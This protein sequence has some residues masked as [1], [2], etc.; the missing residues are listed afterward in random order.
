MNNDENFFGN[1]QGDSICFEFEV[2]KNQE[3]KEDFDF[4]E[5]FQVRI[6]GPILHQESPEL[7]ELDLRPEIV[8]SIHHQTLVTKRLLPAIPNR[9]ERKETLYEPGLRQRLQQLLPNSKLI[10]SETMSLAELTILVDHIDLPQEVAQQFAPTFKDPRQ[11]MEQFKEQK[12]KI[13]QDTKQDIK[14]VS[15]WAIKH[16]LRFIQE[17]YP[18]MTKAAIESGEARLIGIAIILIIVPVLSIDI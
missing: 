17:L 2:Q 5:G 11:D 8:E 1:D 4:R 7:A 9:K 10:L 14:L 18:T 12:R 6:P 13:E 15:Q 3:Q 16:L